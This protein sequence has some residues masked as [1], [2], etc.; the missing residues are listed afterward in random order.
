MASELEQ[1]RE[2]WWWDALT[3]EQRTEILSLEQGDVIPD[4]YVSQMRQLNL[5]P[6]LFEWEG[7]VAPPSVPWVGLALMQFLADKRQQPN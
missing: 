5:T 4:A 2:A 6:P 7:Q 3:D 1:R